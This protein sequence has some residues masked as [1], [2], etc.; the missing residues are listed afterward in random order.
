MYCLRLAKPAEIVI[1]S[2]INNYIKFIKLSS[3]K[4]RSDQKNY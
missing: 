1:L 4:R 3:A 2:I